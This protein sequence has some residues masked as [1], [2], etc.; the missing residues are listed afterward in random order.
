MTSPL[1]TLVSVVSA[2]WGSYQLISVWCQLSSLCRFSFRLSFPC[3]ASQA[4]MSLIH[5]VRADKGPTFLLMFMNFVLIMI[6]MNS[7]HIYRW[8]G[9]AL[10]NRNF[11]H[12][13]PIQRKIWFWRPQWYWNHSEYLI[14]R[15]MNS[16]A[17]WQKI[18]EEYLHHFSNPHIDLLVWILKNSHLNTINR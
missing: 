2:F 10:S 1:Q 17:S 3:K 7:G 18:K 13:Q 9:S 16:L 4:D 11:G 15:P 5:H 14:L 6:Y 12:G 8:T